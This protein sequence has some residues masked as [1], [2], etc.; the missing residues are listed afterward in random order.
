M[1]ARNALL[2]IQILEDK[3]G[4]DTMS[5]SILMCDYWPAQLLYHLLLWVHASFASPSL[6]WDFPLRSFH[7]L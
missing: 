6:L 4:T 2:D 7:L 3:W 1:S 5:A